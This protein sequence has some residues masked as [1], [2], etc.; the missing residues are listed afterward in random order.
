MSHHKW[1]LCSKR[2]FHVKL[3]IQKPENSSVIL[4][5]GL[6]SIHHLSTIADNK[7]PVSRSC[8]SSPASFIWVTFPPCYFTCFIDR[9][10]SQKSHRCRQIQISLTCGRVCA[11]FYSNLH[12]YCYTSNYSQFM[13]AGDA[14]TRYPSSSTMDASCESSFHQFLSHVFTITDLCNV[15]ES[16]LLLLLLLLSQVVT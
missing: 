3:Y 12:T 2:T 8:S 16:T 15:W 13:D 14:V 10:V 11:M 1:L 7:M 5:Q 9:H 4:S 6:L